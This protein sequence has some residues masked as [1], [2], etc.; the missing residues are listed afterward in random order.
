MDRLDSVRQFRSDVEYSDSSARCFLECSPFGPDRIP[1]ES[2]VVGTPPAF[3]ARHVNTFEECTTIKAVQF[4]V[5][6][7]LTVKFC[8]AFK[9]ALVRVCRECRQHPADSM[10]A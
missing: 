9:L 4:A 6:R 10:P 5:G 7:Q 2:G 1:H 8:E 3:F